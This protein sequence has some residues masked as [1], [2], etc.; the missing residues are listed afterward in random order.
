MFPISLHTAVE[1]E[2]CLPG[3]GILTIWVDW[4]PGFLNCKNL[5]RFL[6]ENNY[7]SPVY[8]IN[9]DSFPRE[10]QIELLGLAL[11]GW[12]EIFVFEKGKILHSFLGKDSF[13]KFKEGYS[14][15]FE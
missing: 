2:K 1:L 6:E 15:S 5:Y 12:G 14:G 9:I 13:E 3:S 8:E 10:K 4:S 7:T 11:Y